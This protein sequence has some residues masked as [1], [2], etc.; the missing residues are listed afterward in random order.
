MKAALIPKIVVKHGLIRASGGGDF[1]G[2]SAGHSFRREMLLG[3]G[4]NSP[5][6]RRVF[7][8]FSSSTHV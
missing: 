5:R 1:V 7:H 4:Q 8:F 6:C 3:S 2:A